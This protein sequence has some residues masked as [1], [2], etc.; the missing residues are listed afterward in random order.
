MEQWRIPQREVPVTLRLDSG[1]QCSGKFFVADVVD[2]GG[3]AYSLVDRL[4]DTGE[5]FLAFSD[6]TGRLLAKSSVLYLVLDDSIENESV[7]E[8]RE[9]IRPTVMITLRDGSELSGE[10]PFSMPPDRQRLLD[11]LNA[12]PPFLR[13]E[14]GG[15]R[16]LVNR[17]AIQEI[18]ELDSATG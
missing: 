5:L 8:A 11:Y 7:G 12:A 9:S 15:R 1:R 17:D 16:W 10:L 14:K 2:A 4:N 3:R 18:Q 6:E 13:L